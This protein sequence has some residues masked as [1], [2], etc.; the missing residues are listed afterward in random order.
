[1]ASNIFFVVV[2]VNCHVACISCYILPGSVADLKEENI[3]AEIKNNNNIPVQKC[4]ETLHCLANYLLLKTHPD[5]PIYC[6]GF[7]P[8]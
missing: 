1:M 2:V 5:M 7:W 8:C 3:P 4:F 6:F